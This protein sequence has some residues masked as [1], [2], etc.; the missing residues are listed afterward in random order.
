MQITSDDIA[1]DYMAGSICFD[2]LRGTL[3]KRYKIFIVEEDDDERERVL[4]GIAQTVSID[5]KYNDIDLMG[6]DITV[7]RM[8]HI[9][10]A[11]ITLDMVP[12]ADGSIMRYENFNEE[13]DIDA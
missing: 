4:S 6:D 5:T 10:G 11:T 1:P 3:P 13:E 2:D 12:N 8:P 9:N 7:L